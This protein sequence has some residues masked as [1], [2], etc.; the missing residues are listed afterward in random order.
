MLSQTQEMLEGFQR[1]VSHARYFSSPL[2]F[3]RIAGILPALCPQPFHTSSMFCCSGLWS[4]MFSLRT[5]ITDVHASPLLRF[6]SCAP[7]SHIRIPPRPPLF[8]LGSLPWQGGQTSCD[9]AVGHR[10]RSAQS[11]QA[12][13][14]N[15]P[16]LSRRFSTA[17]K[18]HGPIC[19]TWNGLLHCLEFPRVSSDH[20][21]ECHT[22]AAV[23]GSDSFLLLIPSPPLSSCSFNAS[24]SS[25]CMLIRGAWSERR[26]LHGSLWSSG[27]LQSWKKKAASWA[28]WMES[29]QVEIIFTAL[30]HQTY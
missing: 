24:Y 29:K 16:N 18:I 3:C 19:Q 7:Y 5:R 13:D 8:L 17:W 22:V 12:P 25:Y 14:D 9:S 23:T 30:F 11:P 6:F 26:L 27:R 2:F 1:K 28:E 20:F 15:L 21:T 4:F 10:T